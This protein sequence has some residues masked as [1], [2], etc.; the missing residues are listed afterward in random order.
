MIKKLLNH[1]AVSALSLLALV[2]VLGGFFNTYFSLRGM[3]AGPFIL[4]FDD[5]QGITQ[6]GSISL[7]LAV[8]ILGIIM[9]VLNFFI[10]LELEERNR[11]LGKIIAGMTLTLGVLLFIAFIVILNVN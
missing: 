1:R 11:A 6:V 2:F 4:H 5:I 8:G 3:G 10:A 7:I 9:I